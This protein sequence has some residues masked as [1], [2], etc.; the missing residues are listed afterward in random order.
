M[1]GNRIPPQNHPCQ[2]YVEGRD[3]LHAIAG[4]L[5]RHGVHYPDTSWCPRI[6]DSGGV[7]ALLET[8]PVAMKGSTAC[9]GFVLDAD[10]SVDDR[11]GRV[12]GRCVSEGVDLE[13]QPSEDGTV[14]EVDG[15]RRGFWLMPDNESPGELEDFLRFLVPSDD[16][17]WRLAQEATNQAI[18]AGAPLGEG[19]A[20]KGS[21]HAWLAWQE[22]PGMPFGTAFSAGV[23]GEDGA[24]VNR[25]VEWLKRLFDADLNPQGRPGGSRS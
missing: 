20:T 22:R 9:V 25:F 1:S 6:V 4:L 18:E 7:D 3:D 17:I 10:A 12:R 8:I 11:W 2:L 21:L 16:A 13:A 14:I 19:Q 5:A 15:R 23:F 24:I